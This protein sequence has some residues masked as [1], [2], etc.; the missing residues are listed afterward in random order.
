MPRN[1]DVSVS[2]SLTVQCHLDRGKLHQTAIGLCHLST[3]KSVVF[4]DKKRRKK[5]SVGH[6]HIGELIV[7]STCI[8]PNQ[9]F[10]AHSIAD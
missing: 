9:Y 4:G 3:G 2:F 10:P 7:N 8:H 5:D 6:T 1:R